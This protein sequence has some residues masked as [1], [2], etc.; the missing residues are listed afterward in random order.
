VDDHPEEP[1]RGRARHDRGPHLGV[2][3]RWRAGHYPSLAGG[4]GHAS[5][6]RS[7]LSPSGL[8][9]V[10]PGR[11]GSCGDPAR[12]ARTYCTVSVSRTY[13]FSPSRSVEPGLARLPSRH[14][15]PRGPATAAGPGRGRQYFRS[16]CRGAE[17]RLDRARRYG[18]RRGLARRRGHASTTTRKRSYSCP[19]ERRLSVGVPRR[20]GSQPEGETFR[21]GPS[22]R[23]PAGLSCLLRR[24][25][26]Y[27]PG[28]PLGYRWR[29]AASDFD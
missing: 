22:R 9:C 18:S 8:S 25:L 23:L 6:V 10:G 28:Q 7:S 21:R 12:P 24:R 17:K 3:I 16:S 29:V 26:A 5:S 4:A 11:P 20:G 27:P 1:N 2:D 15:P 19:L 13:H 14:P